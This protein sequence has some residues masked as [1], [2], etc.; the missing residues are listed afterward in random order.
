M[1]SLSNNQ[2]FWI[3]NISKRGVMLADLALSIPPGRSI[4]LLDSKHFHYTLEQLITSAE[5]GSIFAKQN[6]IKIRNVAP[7]V[8]VK[9]GIYVVNEPRNTKPRSL[10]EIVE[11]HY[12]ELDISDEKF[13]EESVAIDEIVKK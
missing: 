12:E 11:K 2:E 8:A 6:K 3:V 13:A 10:V 1:L 9:P 4:N 5:S 7:Q